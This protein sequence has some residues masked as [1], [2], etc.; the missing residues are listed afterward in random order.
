MELKK[1]K[2]HWL[3]HLSEA[4]ENLSC[5]PKLE[6]EVLTLNINEGHNE[7]LME[8]C[9]ILREY[10]QYVNCVRKYAKELDLNEAVKLA[11]DECIRND[12]LSEFLRAN[13]SEVISMSIFEYDKEEE[14]RKL[15]KAEYESGVADGF[16]DGINTAKKDTVRLHI[17]KSSWF[18]RRLLSGTILT[19]IFPDK[20]C[21][22]QFSF[23]AEYR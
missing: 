5:E 1:K 8:Q 11:V 13:K 3:N 22:D 21:R 9:Q 16:N 10:A 6:L 12:I 17:A 14:E 15:R 2:D 18:D 23:P 20:R 19:S 7:E 4:F